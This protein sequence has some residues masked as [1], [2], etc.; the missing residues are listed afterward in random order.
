MARFEIKG[1]DRTTG[2]SHSFNIST[3]DESEARHVA[4][5]KNLLVSSIRRVDLDD[6]VADSLAN[7]TPATATGHPINPF[8][9]FPPTIEPVYPLAVA[10]FHHAKCLR[11]FPTRSDSVGAG[12]TVA[13]H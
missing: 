11:Q 5:M 12:F 13:V 3:P 4:Q 6:L 7:G 10:F 8:P 1:A 2:N 9:C